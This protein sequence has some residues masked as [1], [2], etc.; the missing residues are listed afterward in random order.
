MKFTHFQTLSSG[1]HLLKKSALRLRDQYVSMTTNTLLHVAQ[2][3]S[4]DH[5]KT[6]RL[7]QA[8]TVSAWMHF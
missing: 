5:N 6:C 1:F 4:P 7:Q 8:F 2:Q 3:L